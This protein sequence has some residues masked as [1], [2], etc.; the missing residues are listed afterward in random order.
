M[1]CIRIDINVLI[2]IDCANI[3][4]VL[5]HIMYLNVSQPVPGMWRALGSLFVEAHIY[6]LHMV[7]FVQ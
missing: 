1:S 2:I 4:V 5:L 6:L 3:F 7:I